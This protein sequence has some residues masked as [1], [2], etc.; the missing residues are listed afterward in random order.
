[1]RVNRIVP[2]LK[3]T[4]AWAGHTF[5]SE[6]L[7]L[8]K[9]FDIGWIATFR[10]PDNRSMQVS[11]VSADA[12]AAEDSAVISVDVDDVDAA[13]DLA[14]RLGYDIVHP[15][16]DETWG[17]RRFFVRDPYGNVINIVSHRG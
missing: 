5:Y 6:F 12:T 4:D 17:V 2:N 8:E 3:A 11:L 10:S 7:G 16:T 14:Q 13:Y 1:M 15:L 9:A